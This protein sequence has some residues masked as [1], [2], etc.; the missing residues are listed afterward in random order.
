MMM[1]TEGI[2]V[3]QGVRGLLHVEDATADC[4]TTS[5]AKHHLAHAQRVQQKRFVYH[6]YCAP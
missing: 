6:V 5:P 1:M 3:R 4:T 2:A